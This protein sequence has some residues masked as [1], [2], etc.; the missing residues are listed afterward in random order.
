MGDAQQINFKNNV[1]QI[2]L[3]RVLTPS[4]EYCNIFLSEAITFCT[5]DS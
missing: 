4:E 2:I 5:F 3:D 1:L